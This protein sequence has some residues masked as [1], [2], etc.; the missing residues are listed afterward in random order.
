MGEDTGTAVIDDYAEQL[1]YKFTGTLAK[2]TVDLAP[3]SLSA[4]E[5]KEIEEGAKAIKSAE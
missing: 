2:L 5:Q 4:K 3:Q 1:P